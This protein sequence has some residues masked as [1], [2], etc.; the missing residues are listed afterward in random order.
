MKR[1]FWWFA[2]GAACFVG[3]LATVSVAAESTPETPTFTSA[4]I[5]YVADFDLD[6]ANVK[7]DDSRPKRARRLIGSLLPSG[8]VMP[9][10]DPQTHAR[11]IVSSMAEKITAD[12]MKVGIDARRLEPGTTPTEPGWLVRGV[13]L[14]VDEGNRIKRAVVG[15]GA[16]QGS[17]QLAVAIDNLAV[18]GPP[19]YENVDSGSGEPMP[20]AM[21]KLNPRVV[22]AKFVLAGHDEAS[23]IKHTAQDVADTVV[24]RLHAA[25][26]Q[27]GANAP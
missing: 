4:P 8:P 26:K 23:I 9:D 17:L 13:F 10:Q 25:P 2:L 22:A 27:Q 18:Q 5:V 19:L 20:G 15:F 12:L 16:G 6:A 21:I 24:K 1:P 3:A 14:S 7:P 11:Q